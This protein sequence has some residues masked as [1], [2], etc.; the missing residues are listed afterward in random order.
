MIRLVIV[1]GVIIAILLIF[2]S[3][4][5]KNTNIS[6]NTYKV[7]IISIIVLG[8]LY[9]IATSGRYILPQFIQLIK[10]GLPFLTKFIGI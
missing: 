4:S 1:I 2:R 8:I 3:S 9:L 7:I 5:K 10:L 6:R